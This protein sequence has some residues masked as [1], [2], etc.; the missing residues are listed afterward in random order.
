MWTYPPEADPPPE[1]NPREARE[2]KQNLHLMCARAQF[3]KEV[4]ALA[5]S[6]RLVRDTPVVGRKVLL[7]STVSEWSIAIL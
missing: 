2:A 5:R 1:E 6:Q 3:A 7:L 4:L